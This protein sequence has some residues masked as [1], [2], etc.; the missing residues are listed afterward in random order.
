VPALEHG[1]D[2]RVDPAAECDQDPLAT[3][4][5]VGEAL[6]RAREPR[7]RTMEGIGGELCGVGAL[8]VE[9]S[10]HRRD[11]VGGD[12]CGREDGLAV[13][14]LRGR[15]CGRPRSRAPLGVEAGLQVFVAYGEGDPNQ[16]AARSAARGANERPIRDRPAAR[17]VAQVRLQRIPIHTGQ[18]R[19]C[20]GTSEGFGYL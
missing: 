3:R 7:E 16:V 18:I 15:R 20:A 12:R 5:R 14:R 10:E 9:S 11:L 19:R 4:R 6:V 2:R 13:G 1:R 8:G 17:Y